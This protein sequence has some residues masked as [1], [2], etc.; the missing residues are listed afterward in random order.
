MRGEN[1]CLGF[2]IVVLHLWLNSLKDIC[3]GG[4]FLVKMHVTDLLLY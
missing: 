3:E 4:Q 2:E 1:I